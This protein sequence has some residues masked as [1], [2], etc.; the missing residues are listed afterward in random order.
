MESID[1]LLGR[2]GALFP[3][4]R[5]R[6]RVG[7][8][9]SFNTVGKEFLKYFIE[10]GELKP[11]AVILDV[12]CGIGRMA[13][14]LT[15]YLD[16]QG[17]YEGF[18]I[19]SEGI[20]WASK[21]IAPKFPNFHFQ[22]VDIYNKLYNPN[23]KFKAKEFSFPYS[24]DS[25]D[26]VFLTSVFTHILPEDM[27]NYLSEIYRVMKRGG[28]CLI[29]FFLLNL[30]SRN[31]IEAKLSH[32]DFRYELEGCLV[33]NESKPEIAIAYDEKRVRTLYTKYG[34]SIIEPIHYGSW[35]K[36]DN[37]LSFQDI[38]IAKK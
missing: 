31:L 11:N 5:L 2:R 15:K 6:V 24:N 27:E 13:V 16:K 37:Y 7:E 30:E 23:G 38:V 14:A 20:A 34:L 3:P 22:H 28:K 21:N 19:L 18:D 33:V 12:G 4:R 36:R 26:F 10:L 9:D 32:F 17:S 29:T 35:S 25:F 8:A 1:G